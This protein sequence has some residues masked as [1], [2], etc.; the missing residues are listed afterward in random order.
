MLGVKS[1]TSYIRH[2]VQAQNAILEEHPIY[3][4]Q[5]L[6]NNLKTGRQQLL[7]GVTTTHVENNW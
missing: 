5:V 3:Q 2:Y 6:F 4:P 7:Q 1:P